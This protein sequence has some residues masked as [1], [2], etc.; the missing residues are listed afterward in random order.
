MALEKLASQ[1]GA[2]RAISL[3]F[4]LETVRLALKGTGS[5]FEGDYGDAL[6]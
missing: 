1:K 4:W 2:G 6:S 3:Y 5:D